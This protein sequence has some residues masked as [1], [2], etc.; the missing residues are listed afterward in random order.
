MRNI[1]LCILCTFVA[2]LFAY[3]AV[4]FDCDGVLVDTEGMKFVAWQHA[5]QA[6]NINFKLTE[7]FPL[8][9][10]SSEHIAKAIQKQKNVTFD[11]QQMIAE[12]D[13]IYNQLQKEGVPI[14]HD[15]V[16][17]LKKLIRDKEIYGT[18]LG[19]ASSA[20]RAEILIN[21]KHLG[22][23]ESDF[24]VILSGKDDLKEFKDS[25]GVNKPKPYIYQKMAVLLKISPD[26]CLVFEDSQ[27]GV[28][29]AHNAGMDVIAV[30]NKFTGHH[31]FSKALKIVDAN[32]INVETMVAMR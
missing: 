19:L 5:L 22:V 28:E 7:Y 15:A 18:K 4:I 8:V 31:D 26:Q 27:P 17:Y 11:T 10:F 16:H 25:E 24:D 32:Y 13:K 21:L 2:P 9:G 6:K 1:L 30:P 20:S 14:F 3:Q 29:A 12:K 23:K